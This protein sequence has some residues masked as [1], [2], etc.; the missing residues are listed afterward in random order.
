MR[1]IKNGKLGLEADASSVP[2]LLNTAYAAHSWCTEGLKDEV[3]PF[4]M[5]HAG[6]GGATAGAGR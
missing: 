2:E 5:K 1:A 3:L 4:L 6:L